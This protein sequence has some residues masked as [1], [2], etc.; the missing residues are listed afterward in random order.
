MRLSDTKVRILKIV[1]GVGITLLSLSL[2]I[3]GIVQKEVPV[4]GGYYC[5]DKEPFGYFFFVGF[6]IA[7][8]GLGV[9]VVRQGWK[10]DF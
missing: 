7:C 6:Y 2:A 9:A 8:F 3:Y 1:V 10:N 5:L 4:K